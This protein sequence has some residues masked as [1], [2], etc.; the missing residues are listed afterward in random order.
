MLTPNSLKFA[1]CW[2]SRELTSMQGPG[3]SA[4]PPLTILHSLSALQPWQNCTHLGHR[5]TQTLPRRP[6][7]R[8]EIEKTRGKSIPYF[9]IP[10]Q[11]RRA[12][13]TRSFSTTTC[14]ASPSL[15]CL[16]CN[17]RSKRL[18]CVR[19]PLRT[20]KHSTALSFYCHT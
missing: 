6:A 3:A 4:L 12:A 20:H 9:F 1:V 13:M 19:V 14:R 17:R 10:P 16:N 11:H 5:T 7:R 15:H 8:P 18:R 2:L